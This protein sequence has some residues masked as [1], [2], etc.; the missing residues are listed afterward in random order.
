MRVMF[1]APEKREDAKR[2]GD[3]ESEQFS[4]DLSFPLRFSCQRYAFSTLRV[5][6]V[7]PSNF[8]AM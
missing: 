6:L 4:I 1:S 2:K 5:L 3:R 8:S 7:A